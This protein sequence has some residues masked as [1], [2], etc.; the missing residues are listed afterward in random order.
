MTK[1]AKQVATDKGR[2]YANGQPRTPERV[3][4]SDL[5][6]RPFIVLD[7]TKPAFAHLRQTPGREFISLAMSANV[8]E[9]EE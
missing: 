5:R 2:R 7:T 9:G 8:P 3:D 6:H 4:T 1:R